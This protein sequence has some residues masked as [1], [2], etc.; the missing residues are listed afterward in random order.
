MSI[1]S[2]IF[3][4]TPQ[5]VTLANELI[6]DASVRVSPS[7]KAT[8]SKY[9]I[10]SGSKIVDNVMLEN[11]TLQVDGII[12]EA[13]LSTLQSLLGGIIGGAIGTQ[14]GGL[15]G[16]AA[17]SAQT[18]LQGA[19]AALAGGSQSNIRDTI[20]N[21]NLG[22]TDFPK[23]AWEYLLQVQLDRFPFSIITGFKEYSDMILTDV[24][25]VQTSKDGGSLRFSITCEQI[26]IITTQTV[27]IPESVIDAAASNSASSKGNGGRK[28]TKAASDSSRGSSV[29]SDL[30]G[31]G[32]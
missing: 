9:P 31:L 16:A 4:R 1:T 14:V 2:F 23:K 30:T 6:I 5:P 21:R 15:A 32:A 26:Q 10:E 27:Q 7:R 25:S 24:N 8:P 18:A 28:S 17:G 11:L 20:K 19:A 3:G 22:D 12:S 29:L 13:P